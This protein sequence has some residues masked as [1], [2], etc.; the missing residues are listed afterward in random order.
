M[1]ISQWK[2]CTQKM[3]DGRIL[4]RMR[5]GKCNQLGTWLAVIVLSQRAKALLRFGRMLQ[6]TLISLR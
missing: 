3:Q 5:L 4:F 6:A 1:P 2:I